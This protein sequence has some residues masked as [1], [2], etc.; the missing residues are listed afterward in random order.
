VPTTWGSEE[1]IT[2]K[3]P[4]G[5]Q[6]VSSP[7]LWDDR[8]IVS[9]QVGRGVLRQGNHPTLVRGEGA[10]D[11]KSLRA[12]RDEPEGGTTH[13]LV[14]VFDRSDGKRLWEYRLEAEGDFPPVHRKTNMANASPVT[15]GEGVY[16]WFATGQLVALDMNGELLWQRHIAREYAPFDI[17]WGHSSSPTLY[18]DTIILLCDHTPASYL[19]A[20]DKKSG[21]EKWKT[22]R[23]KGLRGYSTPF[24][25]RG[26]NHDELIVNSSEGVD[27]YDPATGKHLWYITEPNRFPVP[28]PSFDDGI[29][30]MSRGHRSGPYMALRLGGKGDISKSHIKWRVETGAPY[31][32]SVVYYDGLVYMA[33]GA[34]IVRCVDGETGERV[35]QER[36]GGIFSASPV[37]ADGKVYLLA[38]DGEMVVL[39]AGRE[40]KVLSRNRIEERT[41]ASPAISNGQIFLRTDEHLVCVGSEPTS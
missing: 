22:D 36:M 19:V 30:Y 11:E 26:K 27:A 32:S 5:G 35:W 12:S 8:V 9:S 17:P 23:G 28:S 13:F 3:V 10:A 14:E 21:K 25:A 31:V 2:W 7:I 20:F 18:E 37:A 39:E 40:P 38:E 15:D 33:N 34:G 6:A 4:L 24:V 1:N 16:A 41:V 29:V